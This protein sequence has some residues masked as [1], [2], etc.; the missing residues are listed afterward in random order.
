MAR[1]LWTLSAGRQPTDRV[2]TTDAGTPLSD[3]NLR[4]RVFNPATDQ[5][6]V[7]W[8]TF[9]TLRHTCASLLFEAGRDVKQ[10]SAWLGHADPAFTLRTYIHLMDDGVGDA[11]FLDEAVKVGNR[12]ATGHPGTAANAEPMEKAS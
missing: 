7:P 9:H 11:A 1:R 2:F 4:R 3:S 6:G 12:W 10:V 5:A 8:A